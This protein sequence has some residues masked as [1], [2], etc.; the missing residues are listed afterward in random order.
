LFKGGR[1]VSDEWMP[2]LELKLSP[3]EFT[4]LPRNA[5]YKYHYQ[6]GAAWLN[7]RP[8]YY[9]AALDLRGLSLEGTANVSLRPLQIHEMGALIDVFA[10]AFRV[11]QPFA[12]LTDAARRVAAQ[13]SLEQALSGGDGPWIDRASFVAWD[14]HERRLGAI[15]ITLLPLRNPT[16]FDCYSWDDPPPPDA[17]EKRLGRPHLTWIFVRPTAAGRGVGTALLQ[18]AGQALAALGFEELLTTF[19]LGNDSSML[20]H[21]RCG[22]RVLPYPGSVRRL[23]AAE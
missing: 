1:I 2:W 5:A 6:A 15:L 23:P 21:W 16:D 18:A 10:D 19:M 20:W 11:E 9:H 4:Q 13:R 3:L 12:G 22:F 8:R 17:I 14:G 7:P